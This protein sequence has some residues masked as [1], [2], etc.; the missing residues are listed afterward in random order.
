MV[1]PP[2]IEIRISLQLYT[3]DPGKKEVYSF[4]R[5]FFFLLYFGLKYTKSGTGL[6]GFSLQPGLG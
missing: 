4:N 5:T 6:N 3:M 1:I 2:T